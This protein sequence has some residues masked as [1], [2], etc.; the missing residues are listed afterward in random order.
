MITPEEPLRLETVG[1]LCNGRRRYDPASKQRL[2]EACLQPGVSLAGLALHHGVNANLL[3]KWVAKRQLQNG[4]DQPE[5]RAPIAPAFIPVCATERSCAGRLTASM[6]N[7]VTL[8]LEGGDAQLLS[9][10]IEAL[11]RCDVPTGV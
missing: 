4:D 8:S 1:V 9:A 11:G 7:G 3:R 6:P 5:A 2:V 10:V